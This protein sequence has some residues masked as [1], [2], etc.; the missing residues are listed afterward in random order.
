MPTIFQNLN[1][2]LSG[3]KA[4]Q[5]QQLAKTTN[6]YSLGNQGAA[7]DV[8]F[9]TTNQ[10]E[11][12]A[13]RLE[14]KQQRLM[15]MQ[16]YK[17]GL[18]NSVRSVQEFTNVQMMY[19]DAQIM[20]TITPEIGAALDIFAEEACMIGSSG[21]MLNISSKSD[22]I[23]ATLEDLFYN[24]LDLHVMLPMICRAMCKYGNEFMLLN[25]DKE[26]G[27]IGWMEL[28]IF[29]IIRTEN[30]ATNPYQAIGSI[31]QN[32]EIKNFSPHFLWQAKSGQ[33]S[34]HNLQIAHFR[35]ITDSTFLPYGVSLL[36]K[37]RR[38]WRMLSMMEDM[39]LIYRLERSIE[40]RVFKIFT[41]DIDEDDIPTYVQQ[42]ANQFKRT[43]IIDPDTGQID[44]RKNFLSVDTDYFIPF[45]QE[46]R[47]SKIE[48]LNAATNQTSMDDIEYMRGKMLAALRVPKAFLN[49]QDAQGKGQNLSF[50]DVR[51]S[52]MINRVQQALLMELTKVAITHLYL[53]GFKDEISN[54][55]LTMHN[56]SSQ[57]QMQEL[58]M[59]TK[60]VQAMQ[61]VLA[62]PGNGIQIYSYH[63]ALKEIMQMNDTEIA[64]NLNEIRLERALAAELQ[65]TTQIIKKT[66]IFD[67]TDRI[68]GDPTAKYDFSQSE[69]GGP[70]EGGPGA[71]GPPAGGMDLG[72]EEMDDLGAPGEEGDGD[73]GGA[74]ESVDMD[75]APAADAGVPLQEGRLP[76]VY[77]NAYMRKLLPEANIGV[78]IGR[79]KPV[80]DK[81][82]INEELNSM[83]KQLDKLV[84]G[85]D[86]KDIE[87]EEA[88]KPEPG[89]PEAML[90]EDENKDKETPETIL[91]GE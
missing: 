60:K 48:T 10:A 20:D 23:K 21:K 14:A 53:L 45:R 6:I 66:G 25:I 79:V 68:Y 22:R 77:F 27:V 78:S 12:E 34:F 91:L 89:S 41:G 87:E 9:T 32:G 5:A 24:R 51:F 59:L 64:E 3:E 63:R 56:P 86:L 7:N 71:G 28:P 17:A 4:V 72:G 74:E 38:S 39:M 54:F 85:I 31:N 36:H 47:S 61:Q 42:V 43:E 35:I 18:D 11:F 16:F 76:D 90:L 44:L 37:A 15:S 73:I 26:M 8:I 52:R 33:L 88:N 70:G 1:R 55:T 2:V 81:F 67:P 19:R 13:K 84:E 83:A 46:D 30:G 65:N 57:V 69:E 58:D 29:E 40:R 50:M 62:D 75:S 49:F 82:F 80:E